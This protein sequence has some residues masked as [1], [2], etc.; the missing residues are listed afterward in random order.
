MIFNE[1]G[2]A[3]NDFRVESDNQTH[4]VFVDAGSDQ[5]MV[6]ANSAGGGDTYLFVSGSIGVKDST[7]KGVA[8]F[9]G[10]TVISG[11]LHVSQGISG[12]LTTLTDG[13]EYLIAGS[14]VTITTGSSGQITV[15]VS[16]T[17]NV[18]FNETP[19]G[20]INGS[21]TAF[22]LANS[23]EEGTVMLFVNGQ[24]QAS[25]SGLDYT[26]SNKTLTF[27]GESVP[28]TSDRLISTYSKST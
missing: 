22:T 20:S 28:Q 21:N 24:L 4:A 9:G 6:G 10:D 7:T 15:A 17:S 18:V 16:S 26:L 5:V 23:P 12:S 25:G 19:G 13:T 14:N 2:H 11:A 3:T 8:V 1:D 27:S